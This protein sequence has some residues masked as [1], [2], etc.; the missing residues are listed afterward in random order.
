MGRSYW[1]FGPT[2]GRGMSYITWGPSASQEGLCFRELVLM[3]NEGHCRVPRQD[4]SASSLHQEAHSTFF[5]KSESIDLSIHTQH[6]NCF[7]M[8][9]VE[10]FCTPYRKLRLHDVRLTGVYR[11]ALLILKN[12]V[13]WNVTSCGSCKNRRFGGKYRHHHHGDMNW[14]A[15]INVSSN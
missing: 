3:G 12:V 10:K 8:K 13:F 6:N 4:R 2:K 15:R 14:R 5:H 11:E 7:L 1:T 9:L